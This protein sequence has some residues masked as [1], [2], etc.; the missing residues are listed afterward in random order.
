MAKKTLRV[1][2]AEGLENIGFEK[3]ESRSNRY[4]VY[5]GNTYM[6]YGTNP[7]TTNEVRYVF[8]SNRGISLRVSLTPNVSGFSL[9]LSESV[10]TRLITLAGE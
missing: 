10:K 3:Q 8:V 2:F 5:K 7:K 9:P 4:N 1:L 6:L